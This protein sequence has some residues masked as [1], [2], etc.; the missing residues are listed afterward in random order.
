M[1]G[2]AFVPAEEFHPLLGADEPHV[3]RNV[4]RV[5]AARDPWMALVGALRLRSDRDE[6]VA[7]A[8]R[9]VLE[10]WRR[11]PVELYA[12]PSS[13]Q[14]SEIARMMTDLDDFPDVRNTL[15]RLLQV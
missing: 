5:V 15:E 14:R 8:A 13:G 9:V 6:Q 4:L 2:R 10:K 12:Q 7:R 1:N 3:R 11:P